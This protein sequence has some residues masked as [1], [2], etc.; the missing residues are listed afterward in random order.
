MLSKKEVFERAIVKIDNSRGEGTAT[1]DPEYAGRG[2]Y[3]NTVE[4]I[5]L[6]GASGVDVGYFI[7]KV[8]A[9]TGE[10]YEEYLPERT[11]SLG[12]SKIYY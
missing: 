7:A 12:Y 1:L 9:E 10:D 4:G 6:D 3:G 2:M 11:D 8:E 5:V